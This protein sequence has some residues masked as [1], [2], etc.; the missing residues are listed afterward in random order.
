MLAF[1]CW[2]P[3]SAYPTHQ[4]AYALLEETRFPSIS[5]SSSKLRSS[6]KASRVTF[7][8]L[9]SLRVV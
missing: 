3:A 9:P 5:E 1:V 8:P 6:K 7:V 2:M 4:T